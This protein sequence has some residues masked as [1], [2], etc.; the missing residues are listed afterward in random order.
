MKKWKLVFLLSFLMILLP[1]IYV[2]SNSEPYNDY[3][4]E[5]EEKTPI[6]YLFSLNANDSVEIQLSRDKIGNISVFLFSNRPMNSYITV[7]Q[8]LDEAIYENSIINKTSQN[9][10]INYTA[11]QSKIYYLEILIFSNGSDILRI[12]ST[13]SLSRYYLPQISGFPVIIFNATILFSVLILILYQKRK[14]ENFKS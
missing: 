7:N 5:I 9:P 10:I 4:I 6:F 14:I 8:T 1:L 2:T 3:A 11:S 12:K 13:R